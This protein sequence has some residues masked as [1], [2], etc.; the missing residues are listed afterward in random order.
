MFKRFS[1]SASSSALVLIY[2]SLMANSDEHLFICLLNRLF[3]EVSV[4]KVGLF[5]FLLLS[6]ENLKVLYMFWIQAQIC[7]ICDLQL[8]FS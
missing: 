1:C 7:W 2:I 3:G 4:F 8:F 6:F 5:V